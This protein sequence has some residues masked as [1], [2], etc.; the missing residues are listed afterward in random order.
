MKGFSEQH[1]VCVGRSCE[2]ENTEVNGYGCGLGHLL[3]NYGCLWTL[4]DVALCR[5]EKFTVAESKE[6][7]KRRSYYGFSM[8]DE[9]RVGF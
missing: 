5:T 4:M 3:A 2:F 8:N 6:E 1:K 9:D 7:T